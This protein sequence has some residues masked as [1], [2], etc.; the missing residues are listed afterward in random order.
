MT[1][2]LSRYW[3]LVPLLLVAI[4]VRNWVEAPETLSL[5]EPLLM[6][7][8]RAD[9]YLED[10]VTR[11]YD[12]DGALAYLIRGETLSHFPDDD[13]A[14]I[15]APDIELYLPDALWRVRADDGRLVQGIIGSSRVVT[16]GGGVV[17]ERGARDDAGV[18][19][20]ASRPVTIRADNLALAIDSNEVSTAGPVEIVSP[21]LSLRALG[22]QS[23]I[24]AG[25]LDLLSNVTGTYEVALPRTAPGR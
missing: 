18:D 7:D 23:S 8:I 4:L 13:R 15:V 24:D 20:P 17:L 6:R 16:L 2:L 11:R 12:K 9:Y 5:E 14:E 22:L 21:G 1:R 3:L 10:F 25:K 19:A